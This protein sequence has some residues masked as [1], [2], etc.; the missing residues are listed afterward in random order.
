MKS[1]RIHV[2]LGKMS[3]YV[4]I[5]SNEFYIDQEHEHFTPIETNRQLIDEFYYYSER[6]ERLIEAG[7]TENRYEVIEALSGTNV[8]RRWTRQH[9]D[10][11]RQKYNASNHAS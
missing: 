3:D 11:Q 4:R 2:V 8:L 7:L 1:L 9:Y 10:K 6:E 5:Y